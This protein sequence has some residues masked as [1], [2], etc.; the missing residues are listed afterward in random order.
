MIKP[1]VL[2]GDEQYERVVTWYYNDTVTFIRPWIKG[3]V[4]RSDKYIIKE[5]LWHDFTHYDILEALG[6]DWAITGDGKLCK[7]FKDE[8]FLYFDEKDQHFHTYP[9][10]PSNLRDLDNPEYKET[11]KRLLELLTNLP[12]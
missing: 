9:K 12:E 6:E 10:L 1:N 3:K 8:P 11:A 2:C 5:I 7:P 4:V